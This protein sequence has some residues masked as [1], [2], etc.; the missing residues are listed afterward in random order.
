MRSVIDAEQQ[1]MKRLD[2]V[3]EWLLRVEDVETRVDQLLIRE[4]SQQVQKSCLCGFCPWN[5]CSSCKFGKE[6]DKILKDVVTLTNEGDFK[7]VGEKIPEAKVGLQSMVDEVWSSLQ[8]EQVGTIGLYGLG[9]VG[10]TTLLIEIN[11]KLLR[12]PNEFDFVIRVVP[13]KN[14]HIG[15]IQEDIGKR[16]GLSD[17]SW[18]E[19]TVREKAT[20]IFR[21]LSSK[22]FALLLDDLWERVDLQEVGVPRPSPE[23][24]SK[25]L[26]TTREMKVCG[27]MGVQK[28]FEVKCLSDQEAWKLFQSKVGKE[29]LDSHSDIPRLAA[30]VADECAG[31][32]LHTCLLEE[33]E[34]NSHVKM[35]DVVRDM[36]MWIAS[37]I[38]K[39]K[40]KFLIHA[41]DGLSSIPDIGKWEE[42]R[43]ISYMNNQITATPGG[44]PK[45]PYLETLFLNDNSLLILNHFLFI[46][47]PNLKVLN[48]S[49][50]HSLK[51]LPERCFSDLF[52]LQHLDLSATGIEILPEDL[53]ALV[54]LKYLNLERTYFLRKIPRESFSCLLMLQVLRMFKCGYLCEAPVDS[55]LF[56][57]GEYLVE[58]L[59]RLKDLNVLS[60]TLKSF[61]ALERFLSSNKLE[62]CT[63]SLCLQELDDSSKS[64]DVLRLAHMERLETLHIVECKHLEEMKID[65]PGEVQHLRETHFQGLHVVKI[66]FCQ[67]LKDLTWLILAPNLKTVSV[68][69]CFDIKELIGVAKW[70]EVSEMIENLNVFENLET[71]RLEN[72][73]NLKSM[74]GNALPFPHLNQM[75]IRSCSNVKKLPLDS[76]S[77]KAR[78]IVIKGEK[79]WWK[80]LRWE[81][82][83]TENAFR[84]CFI[85]HR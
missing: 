65:V 81:D 75:V 76:N 22:K 47:K 20:D 18:K 78:K 19:K 32:L 57:G 48:L 73:P 31:F 12:T 8:E 10:K 42:M 52:F 46:D 85:S 3:H 79:E 37:E 59:F 72:L 28:T 13:S 11:N 44:N 39:E 62:N 7:E 17:R 9:G 29:T 82:K 53:K 51:R 4:R 84:S 74:Y 83:A 63:E 50:N 40:E 6:L 80:E 16:I 30:T 54:N 77:A 45:C 14:M 68:S 27:L 36:S 67:K 56:G 23:N 15:N 58:E 24:A 70:S 26:F 34:D 49:Y 66:K 35:H 38:E 71:L 2:S 69:N 21:I 33:E 25:V 43:R 60:I 41:G 5:C 61:H 55:I 1:Q 64:L